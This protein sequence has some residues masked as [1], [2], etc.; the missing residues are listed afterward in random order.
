MQITAPAPILYLPENLWFLFNRPGRELIIKVLGIEG[1]TLNL[2]LG[3]EKFQA[4]IAGAINPEDFKVGENIKVKVLQT[5][6]PV[7]LQVISGEKISSD[8]KI[9]Y[10]ISQVGKREGEQKFH[11]KEELNLLSTLLTDLFVKK[12]KK[13]KSL[14]EGIKELLGDKVKSSALVYQEDKLFIPFLFNDERSWGYVE[15]GP[16]QERKGKVKLFYLKFYGEYLGLVECFISYDER[17]ILLELYFYNQEAYELAK[18]EYKNLKDLFILNQ[19]QFIIK[20]Y[21]EESLPGYILE[22]QV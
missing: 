20:L 1:K 19:I 4:R 7:V 9:L 16:P 10:L 3:G 8:L 13:T 15:L 2:E 5:G 14:E 17:E 12:D 18:K 6:N 22:K 11:V 21:L